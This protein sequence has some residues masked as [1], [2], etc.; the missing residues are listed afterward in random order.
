MPEL[1]LAVTEP[2]AK[3]ESNGLRVLCEHFSIPVLDHDP[4][5]RRPLLGA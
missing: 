1:F 5:Y 3:G 4:E 2:A